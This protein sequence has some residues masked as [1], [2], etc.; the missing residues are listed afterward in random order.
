MILDT[1]II[2]TKYLNEANKGIK[3]VIK[4]IFAH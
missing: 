3:N 4:Y 1:Q 2:Y